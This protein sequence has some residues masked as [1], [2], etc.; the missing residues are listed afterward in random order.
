MRVTSMFSLSVT[1][2]M[3]WMV[4]SMLSFTPVSLNSIEVTVEV[5]GTAPVAAWPGS[6]LVVDSRIGCLSPML[7]EA[8]LLLATRTFG[9]ASVLASDSCLKT[10]SRAV[11]GSKNA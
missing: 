8:F 9:A 2:L 7:I 3:R 1:S 6:T 10:S 4:G 5:V 11:V